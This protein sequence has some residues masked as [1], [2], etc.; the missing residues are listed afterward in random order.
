VQVVAGDPSGARMRAEGGRG[1]KV[2]IRH[3]PT[4]PHPS[5]F[6]SFR[7]KGLQAFG[8]F[9]NTTRGWRLA[10]CASAIPACERP[11]RRR[12]DPGDVSH[13]GGTDVD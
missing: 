3:R 7:P 9:A 10:I 1:G 12:R 13:E 6:T 11:P 2:L 4:V 8:L 5:G